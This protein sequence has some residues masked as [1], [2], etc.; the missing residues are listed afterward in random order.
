MHALEAHT[1]FR[2]ANAHAKTHASQPER[3]NNVV[4]NQFGINIF[5]LFKKSVQF[6]FLKWDWTFVFVSY[7]H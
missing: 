7:F 2:Q 6:V 3:T 5:Y 4:E 1:R